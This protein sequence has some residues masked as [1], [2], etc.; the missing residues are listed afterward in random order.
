MSP[1]RPLVPQPAGSATFGV[2]ALDR[3]SACL[4][5]RAVSEGSSCPWPDA[6]ESRSV[7]VNNGPDPVLWDMVDEW[8]MQSFPASDPPANW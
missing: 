1:V 5:V 8:G 4:P 2:L 6:R 3:D 7:T